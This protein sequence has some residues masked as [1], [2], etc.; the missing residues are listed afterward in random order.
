MRYT[1]GAKSLASSQ[2]DSSPRT[3]QQRT[4]PGKGSLAL[5]PANAGPIVSNPF[6][7][8]ITARNGVRL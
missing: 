4:D 2:H 5:H 6:R 3:A 1:T 8:S 7:A